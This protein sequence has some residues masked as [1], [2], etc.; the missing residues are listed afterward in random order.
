MMTLFPMK[1]VWSMSTDPCVTYAFSISDEFDDPS[2]LSKAMRVASGQD[3]HN[4]VESHSNM[5]RDTGPFRIVHDDVRSHLLMVWFNGGFM[6]PFPFDHAGEYED[7]LIEF[8]RLCE[9]LLCI[10]RGYVYEFEIIE[11]ERIVSERTLEAFS[12]VHREFPGSPVPRT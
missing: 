11:T 7:S 4:E 5:L 1:R 2:D 8:E 6:C 3:W 10:L 9:E 12:V